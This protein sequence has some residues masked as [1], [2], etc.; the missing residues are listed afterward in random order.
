VK[1]H[2]G[3]SKFDVRYL[4]EQPEQLRTV[5]QA[6]GL[7]KRT[8]KVENKQRVHLCLKIIFQRFSFC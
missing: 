5:P 4:K 2:A 1:N 3:S 6:S 8:K 7:P